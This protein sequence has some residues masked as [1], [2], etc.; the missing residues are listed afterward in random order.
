MQCQL[1]RAEIAQLLQELRPDAAA[2]A[3]SLGLDDYFLNST[4]G[5]RD[6][7]VYENLFAAAQKAPFNSS[8]KPPGYDHLLWPRFNAS[9]NSNTSNNNK[10]RSK[11]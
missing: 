11:L 4:L 7:D 10:G 2:L 8:H 3:D 5:A 9:S 1:V 6:G